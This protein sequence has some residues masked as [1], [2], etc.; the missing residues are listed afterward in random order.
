MVSYS[1][2]EPPTREA[3]SED[4]TAALKTRASDGVL[5]AQGT[6][7]LPLAFRRDRGAPPLRLEPAP[8][9]KPCQDTYF[10]AGHQPQLIVRQHKAAIVED[11]AEPVNGRICYA[12]AAFFW[13]CFFFLK[14]IITINTG[15]ELISKVVKYQGFRDGP[16]NGM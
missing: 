9:W 12:L 2:L 4:I 5:E 6:Q 14:A 15:Y 1:L 11:K 8:A 16:L 10:T 7:C 3:L 13:F